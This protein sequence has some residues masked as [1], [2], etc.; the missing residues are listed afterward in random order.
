MG[1]GAPRLPS[2]QSRAESP[3]V[4]FLGDD[5]SSVDTNLE[6]LRVAW[7][8]PRRRR[9][10]ERPRPGLPSVPER[11]TSA[12][13]TPASRVR[14]GSV[15][16][17]RAAARLERNGMGHEARLRLLE[18]LHAPP[19]PAPSALAPS[20]ASL[21]ASGFGF[22]GGLDGD[23]ASTIGARSVA[24]ACPPSCASHR[25]ASGEPWQQKWARAAAREGEAELQRRE[26]KEALALREL[27]LAMARRHAVALDGPPRKGD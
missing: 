18:Q 12:P 14:G 24:S 16:P 9:A 3:S 26:L 22:G 4:G 10:R 27:R 8:A 2:V 11:G 19:T 25:V 15:D 23:A 5:A 21:A 17:R 13:P 20:L 1:E 6:H 7:G